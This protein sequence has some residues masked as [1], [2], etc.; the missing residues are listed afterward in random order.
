M[1]GYDR[2]TFDTNIM[3]GRVLIIKLYIDIIQ[4]LKLKPM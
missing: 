1:L 3:G 4:F 2:I